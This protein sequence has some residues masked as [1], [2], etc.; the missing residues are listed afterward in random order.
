MNRVL[1]IASFVA[2]MATGAHAA[3]L[4][5]MGGQDLD[6][7]NYPVGGV[8]AF[9]VGGV[10]GHVT[11]GSDRRASY[12]SVDSSGIGVKTS[13]RDSS[14]LDGNGNEWLTF[15]FEKAVR[16]IAVSFS[17]LDYND[18]WDIYVGDDLV[19]DDN[20]SNPYW[21]SG[22]AGI[23]AKSFKVLAD[24]HRCG[25][26]FCSTDNFV[27]SKVKFEHAPAPVPLPATGLLL[28]G[29]LAGLGFM[30]RRKQQVT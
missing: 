2:L 20:R 5:L 11:A 8:A 16:L 26:I 30:R 15:T 3:T 21:F 7:I 12:I 17:H 13:R 25:W 19:A 1:A 23:V 22:G 18:D 27:I 24:G 14:D 29:G 6:N 10:K 28:I 9:D 4:N